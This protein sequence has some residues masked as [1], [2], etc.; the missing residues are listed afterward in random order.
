MRTLREQIRE[1]LRAA[2]EVQRAE[3][4]AQV[5]AVDDGDGGE[6]RRAFQLAREDLLEDGI[7]FAAMG[8]GRYLRRSGDAGAQTALDQSRRNVRAGLR[9]VE[10]AKA[11]AAAAPQMTDDDHLRAALDRQTDR[12]ELLIATVGKARRQRKF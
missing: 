12:T 3:V 6:F 10:R 11:L 4:A 2:E 7:V 5:D 9:K 8:G 1:I